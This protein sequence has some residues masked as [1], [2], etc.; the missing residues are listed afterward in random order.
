MA[1]KPV[2]PPPVTSRP[3]SKVTK[4]GKRRAPMFE[5]GT[6]EELTKSWREILGDPPPMGTTRS[7]RRAWIVFHKRKW[8]IQAKQRADRR[9]RR[10]IDIGDDS[11][12][13]GVIRTTGSAGLGGFLRRTARSMMDQPWQVVQIAS[14]GHAGLFKVRIVA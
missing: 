9:K 2:A 6:E 11:V 3:L 7:E 1:P 5:P 13:G 4:R 8:E 10:R 14:T 12:G